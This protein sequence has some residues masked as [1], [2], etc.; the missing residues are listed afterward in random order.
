MAQRVQGRCCLRNWEYSAV[1]SGK[2]VWFLVDTRVAVNG[3]SGPGLV[4]VANQSAE[5]CF[6]RCTE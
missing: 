5:A 2:G 3:R 6:Q 4:G 1:C